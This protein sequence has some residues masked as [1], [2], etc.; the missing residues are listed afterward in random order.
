MAVD[1]DIKHFFVEISEEGFLADIIRCVDE[2]RD[3][4]I[5]KL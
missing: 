5:D 2:R 4:W 3:P 1:R